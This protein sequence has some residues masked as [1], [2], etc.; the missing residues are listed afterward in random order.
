M[1]GNEKIGEFLVRI[2]AMTEKQCEEIL[3]IQKSGDKRFFGE[4]AIENGYVD[5]DIIKKYLHAD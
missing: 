3:D 1:S 2:G 5:K 4:I